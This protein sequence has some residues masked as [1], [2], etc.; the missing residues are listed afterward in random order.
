MYRRYYGFPVKQKSDK[1]KEIIKNSE[2]YKHVKQLS[3]IE[4]LDYKQLKFQKD[5]FQKDL[6]LILSE[7]S[8]D[9]YKKKINELFQSIKI[10]NESFKELLKLYKKNKNNFKIKS[11]FFQ[12]D[13]IMFPSK[14]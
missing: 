8:L 13:A 14:V 4:K 1:T 6:N 7:Y 11:R 10:I 9:N 5:L 2:N 3:E 12:E